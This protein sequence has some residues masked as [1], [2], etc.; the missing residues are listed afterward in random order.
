VYF[1]GSNRGLVTVYRG[2][3]YDLPFGLK[4][5]SSNYPSSVPVA[6]L[7]PAL[8]EKLL[9]HQTRSLEGANSLVSAL[10]RG[11]VVDP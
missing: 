5:Y 1:I 9:D 4:L 10:E 6:D 11:Q 7:S 3:P 2:L 8:R